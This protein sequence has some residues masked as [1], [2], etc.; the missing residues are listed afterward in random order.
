MS[1]QNAMLKL[2]MEND[3]RLSQ[4]EVKEVAPLYLPWAQRAINPLPAVLT[5]WGEMAQPW[6]VNLLA[7]SCA[8]FVTTTN[9]GTNF[10][11]LDIRESQT[12]TVLATLSTAAIAANTFTRLRTTTITQPS[13]ANAS[14]SL[15][16]TPTLAPGTIYI[17]PALALLR[18]GN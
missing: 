14:I 9:N 2:L 11:T 17:V 5:I 6:A 15:V 4:T 7:W 12:G 1:D 13:A 18:T 8:V 16:A 10:W 3:R